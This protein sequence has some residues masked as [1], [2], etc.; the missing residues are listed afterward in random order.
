MQIGAVALEELM[1]RDRQKN[2]EIARRP[3]AHAGLAFAGQ[4]DAGAILDAGRNIDRQR[5][6]ARDPP[7][8][9][10]DL[11]RIVDHLAAAH[12]RSDRC[13]RA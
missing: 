3:A 5:A 6:L 8:A 4:P 7:G 11:A 12:G 9:A 1:R 2:I 13:A 10:A